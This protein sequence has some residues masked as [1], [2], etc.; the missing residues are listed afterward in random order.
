M[1]HASQHPETSGAGS[2]R[3][4][5]SGML[6]SGKCVNCETMKRQLE[7][8]ERENKRCSYGVHQCLSASSIIINP[9]YMYY[10]SHFEYCIFPLLGASRL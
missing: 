9:V 10:L 7:E 5:L 3:W 4:S 2:S 1:T 8:K 6:G